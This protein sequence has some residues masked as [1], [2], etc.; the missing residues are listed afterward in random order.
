MIVGANVPHKLT[1]IGT[2]ERRAV[3]LVLHD[4]RE[5]WVNRAHDHG[6]Q[7]KGLCK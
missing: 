7:E 5:P 2:V 1:A 4:S 3:A 6:W